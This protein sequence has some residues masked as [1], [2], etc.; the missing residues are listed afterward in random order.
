MV[1]GHLFGSSFSSLLLLVA[2]KTHVGVALTFREFRVFIS[3]QVSFC[4][5][6][7]LDNGVFVQSIPSE[8]IWCFQTLRLLLL[9]SSIFE[10]EKIS[11][12]FSKEILAFAFV[13]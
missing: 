11:M 10:S 4:D 2:I 13:C 1:I 6:C 12:L 5:T 9:G 3:G 8:K 7:T